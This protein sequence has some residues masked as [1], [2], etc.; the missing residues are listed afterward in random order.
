MYR[1]REGAMTSPTQPDEID[2]IIQLIND[3][4]YT[5]GDNKVRQAI[6]TMIKNAVIAENDY[7]WHRQ[8]AIEKEANVGKISGYFLD[9]IATL[10]KPIDGGAE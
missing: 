4:G 9:R 5:A 2:K 6:T 8:K 3:N 1:M 10:S 7:H